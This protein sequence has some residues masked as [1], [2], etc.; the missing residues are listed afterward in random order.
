MVLHL[1]QVWCVRLVIA[2]STCQDKTN[3]SEEQT[4][5]NVL[6]TVDEGCGHTALFPRAGFRIHFQQ[7]LSLRWQ[8]KAS[9]ANTFKY[10]STAWHSSTARTLRETGSSGK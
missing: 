5:S 7:R 6:W 2:L 9:R 8:S 4:G 3:L 1:P 10:S